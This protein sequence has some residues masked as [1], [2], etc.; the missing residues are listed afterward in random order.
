MQ[1]KSLEM[2]GFKSF[3]DRTQ[4]NFAP[5]IT[6]IVGPN[7]CGKSNV[8]DAIKWV[9]G[10]LS[11]KS[12][13]GEDM[14]DCIFNGS[15]NRPASGFA[16]VSLT[17]D[18]ADGKLPTEFSEVTISRRL[19]RSGESEYLINKQPARRK[20]ILELFLDT[21]VGTDA[22]SIIEQG[23]INV[24]L[25]A[26]PKERRAL[27]DEAA[28]IS[29]YRARKK[30]SMA[31]LERVD[32][33]L[34]RIGDMLKELESNVRS[35]KIQAGKAERYVKLKDDLKDKKTLLALISFDSLRAQADAV[36]ARL[37]DAEAERARVAG[38]ITAVEGEA[39]EAERAEE[40]ARAAHH[41]AS[42]R[43]EGVSREVEAC[44][45]SIE[46]AESLAGHMEEQ[47]RRAADDLSRLKAE[48][49][50][51]ARREAGAREA[52]DQA[53][54]Q[55]REIARGIDDRQAAS[56]AAE[57]AAR[58]L[59]NDREEKKRE[60]LDALEKRAQYRNE[61]A[62]VE[63]H[64]RGLEAQR[65]R[66]AEKAGRLR[67][68]SDDLAAR[69]QAILTEKRTIDEE[70]ARL[71]A[72]NAAA[73]GLLC[74]AR[75][76]SSEA[77]KAL[78]DRR[79]SLAKLQAKLE[80]LR[81]IERQMEGVGAGAKRLIEAARKNGVAGYRG[82]VADLVEFDPAT[83][84]A[85][86]AILGD[87][88][89]AA[90]FDGVDAMR[91]GLAIANGRVAML[92]LDRFRPGR[93]HGH[94]DALA[95]AGADFEPSIVTNPAPPVAD[96]SLA[97][98]LDADF[99]GETFGWIAP[100]VEDT[101]DDLF[102]AFAVPVGPELVEQLFPEKPLTGLLSDFARC[103]PE[104]RPLVAALCGKARIV[105][106]R[107]EALALLA[108][109]SLDAPVAT[110][111]GDVVYPDGLVI[112]GGAR[113]GLIRR[114]A[115]ART[116]AAEAERV[117]GQVETLSKERAARV[118]EEA[119]IE[120]RCKVLR[121]EILDRSHDSIEKKAASE[122]IEKRLQMVRSELQVSECED[123][124]ARE[125]EARLSE[126]AARIAQVLTD[127][128]ALEVRLKEESAEL[129]ERASQATAACAEARRRL[130]ELRVARAEAQG[131]RDQ[132][133]AAA[134]DLGRQIR[135][136]GTAAA[137]AGVRIAECEERHKAALNAV[138]ERRARLEDLRQALAEAARDAAAAETAREQAV[139]A[140]REAARRKAEAET[141]LRSA[142]QAINGLQMEQNT[143][144]VREDAL[145]A[146]F[147]E[148]LGIDLREAEKTL[149]RN[150]DAS[151]ETLTREVEELRRR[152]ENMGG[153][154][155]EAI[156]ELKEKE[157]KFAA[158]KA[159]EQD[160]ISTKAQLEELIR[161]INR[162]SRD[163]L[164]ATLEQTKTNFAEIFR[165]LFGGG[166]AELVTEEGQDVLECGIDIMAKPPGKEPAAISQLSG[167]EKTLT[168]LAF[169]MALFKLK[170]SP[171]CILDE[172]DAPLD[173]A[174][175]QRF[176]SL[177]RD[178]AQGTQF[179]LITH[180][181]KTM[182]TV[183]A[184]YGVTMQERGVS[185]KVSVKV[186]DE[187]AS[188]PAAEPAMA[189]A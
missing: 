37:T 123:A 161:K 15:G 77:G 156:H 10:D 93:I 2:Q 175:V 7:G 117:L 1:L 184:L 84:L 112:A 177:V 185:R 54:A 92:S 82:L 88:A 102:A 87:R 108:D 142:E 48:A 99:Y 95:A 20:D 113:A 23:Q 179:I 43:H 22:Y 61:S 89:Q 91:A 111:D 103:A 126:R 94:S 151:E 6:G 122:G 72:E 40:E 12:I 125:Q 51:L 118:A 140:A 86:E 129:A 21:G 120:A 32:Q 183:D 90:V 119:Q 168:T 31:R 79:E 46:D 42:S 150:P 34:L 148:D 182:S 171:F 105:A 104:M 163:L 62:S 158:M 68:E 41:A 71:K 57:E 110:L 101:A 170:P 38:T 30:E 25:E 147:R 187:D 109:G 131:R 55:L 5:G 165:K 53:E 24:V 98:S 116:L 26:S 4:F 141:A 159:Q 9:L 18:N 180:N 144:S 176:N 16:E 65:T 63:A 85:A 28:G 70:V 59:E 67:G 60:A 75:T 173:E 155:P 36:A 166:K 83:A 128:E 130:E 115:E 124:D 69:L 14:L 33:D 127:L 139:A 27:L 136:A 162:E 29:R 49:E 64:R 188:A 186:V 58:R 169:I 152:I 172:V 56:T 97:D 153:V 13:R 149:Q 19:Y 189:G 135:A 100:A 73:E 143:L 137:Q 50:E 146:R 145:V 114:R 167:G 39:A 138:A 160:L 133:A 96:W 107:E 35:L 157:E 3:A 154:N 76:A 132:A 74:D 44:G 11:A 45:K 52:L 66:A 81:D 164:I 47:A 178:F 80:T 134:A 106:T 8:V 17:F 174:N 181:K 121:G 78:A